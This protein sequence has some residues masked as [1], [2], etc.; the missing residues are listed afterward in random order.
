MSA[1]GNIAAGMAPVIR[2]DTDVELARQVLVAPATAPEFL[3]Q[4]YRENASGYGL[5]RAG[6]ECYWD[7]YL[8]DDLDR[9]H[10][11]ASPL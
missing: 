5:M 1:G 6:M 10:P 4:S 9:R 11:C 3:T 8:A 7:H 2:D